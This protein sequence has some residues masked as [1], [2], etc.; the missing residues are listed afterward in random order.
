MRC[1]LYTCTFCLYIVLS[2]VRVQCFN[3]SFIPIYGWPTDRITRRD[4]YTH[5]MAVEQ[6][7]N[8]NLSLA[9]Q[10]YP[11]W[12]GCIKEFGR[13]TLQLTGLT[14]LFTWLNDCEHGQCYFME[15]TSSRESFHL[16]TNLD[17]LSFSTLALC[18]KG[19]IHC[20]FIWIISDNA[21]ILLGNKHS[22]LIRLLSHSFICFLNGLHE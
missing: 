14:R 6:C 5:A 17:H 12:T 15:S 2:S 3:S 19:K 13:R 21:D 7:R 22:P 1:S 16:A 4:T 8:L 18:R 20:P 9:G 10:Y 11:Y